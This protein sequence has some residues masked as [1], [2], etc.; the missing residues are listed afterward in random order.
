M[1]SKRLGSFAGTVLIMVLTVMLVLIIMLMAT[2]TVVSTASQRIYTKYEEQQAYY[3]AR[4]ALDV[5]TGKLL[6][7]SQYIVSG[8]ETQGY[9]L[10]KDLYT[11]PISDK[12]TKLSPA[13]KSQRNLAFTDST[14][15]YYGPII[16]DKYIDYKVT[17][18]DLNGGSGDKYGKFS[19]DGSTVNIRVE[20]LDRVYNCGSDGKPESGL[21]KKDSMTIQVTA[22][23]FFEGMEGTASVVMKTK[24]PAANMADRAVTVT[25][26]GTMKFNNTAILGGIIAP[27]NAEM[28]NNPCIWG[29]IFIGDGFYSAVNLH[30]TVTDGEWIYIRGKDNAGIRDPIEWK[31]SGPKISGVNA[32]GD[33]AKTP[34]L[35]MDGNVEIGTTTTFGDS[36]KNIRT[37]ITGNLTWT[38]AS[39]VTVY[40]DLYVMGNVIVHQAK[41]LTVT[42]N[43]YVGGTCDWSN[44]ANITVG[45]SMYSPNAVPR[46]GGDPPAVQGLTIGGAPQTNLSALGTTIP[47]TIKGLQ[48]GT[49]TDE[50][51]VAELNA[52]SGNIKIDWNGKVF[53]MSSEQKLYQPYHWYSDISDGTITASEYAFLSS[54]D[55]EKILDDSETFEYPE[56]FKRIHEY[57]DAEHSGAAFGTPVKLQGGGSITAPGKYVFDSNWT[58]FDMNF[59]G[60][61]FI[62]D[63]GGEV[64][65]Y[66]NPGTYS[67]N[68]GKI[69][70]E[71]GTT[72]KFYGIGIYSFRSLPIVTREYEMGGDLYV[73]EYGSDGTVNTLMG[74]PISYY[75]E[76]ESQVTFDTDTVFVGHMYIPR[77]R[78]YN[79]GSAGA[80]MEV[81][82]PRLKYNNVDFVTNGGKK[83]RFSVLGSVICSGYDSGSSQCGGVAFV[84]ASSEAPPTHGQPNLIFNA[85][86]YKRR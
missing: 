52:N 9:F 85:S 80:D 43:L 16:S 81:I 86:E 82:C 19:D 29:D 60:N 77:G 3:T 68:N 17:L 39:D 22:T 51:L 35:F 56:D 10:Q 48:D 36:G 24:A 2:L 69:I 57:V 33:D 41:S 84:K 65:I 11:I 32:S 54:D 72:V 53:N 74:M 20:V 59:N 46:M 73:G 30:T 13:E 62:I 50:Q 12:N 8:T 18:P 27:V 26:G 58:W 6:N 21:R 45:G 37:I 49:K 67:A 70:V 31:N 38:E 5:F 64:E 15:E 14:G 44:N 4:S 28:G 83:S 61:P 76:G 34:N 79:T 63:A 66:I 42:G 71:P 75:F 55:L 23:A 40:G 7:D 1:K 47:I 25:G 78:V